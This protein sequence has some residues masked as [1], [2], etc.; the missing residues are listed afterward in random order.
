MSTMTSEMTN[1]TLSDGLNNST[2]EYLSDNS[3]ITSS[4]ALLHS[5]R[6]PSDQLIPGIPSPPSSESPSQTSPSEMNNFQQYHQFEGQPPVYRFHDESH[7]HGPNGSTRPKR[8]QVK[9]ACTNCQKACKKCDDA[10]PCLRCVKYGIGDGCVNSQRKERKKGVKR[11][12][13][14]KR[15]GKSA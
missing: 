13:Y 10:R 8:R 14:K 11:G 3:P 6:S 7:E 9:N 4:S 15:D 5:I 2:P 12:P 1:Y